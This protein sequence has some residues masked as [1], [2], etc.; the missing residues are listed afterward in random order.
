[1]HL[2][3]SIDYGLRAVLYLA[4]H[5]GTCSSR[6]IS[7]DM[8]IPRDYLIQLAQLLRNAGLI[9]ARPGKNGGYALSKPADRITV[10]EVVAALN[11]DSRKVPR[12]KRPAGG[13]DP[14]ATSVTN[15]Y[16][17]MGDSIDAYLSSITVAALLEA[18]HG[19][20]TGAALIADR[21]TQEAER[22]RG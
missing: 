13:T 19:G 5:G 16:R 20:D 17:L 21:L 10:R 15:A 8:A 22:L 18:T 6:D 7:E 2:K 3:A 14:L 9:V 1:M 12:T 4:A 11:D